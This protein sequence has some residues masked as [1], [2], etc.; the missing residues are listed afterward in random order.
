MRLPARLALSIAVSLLAAPM[1]LACD[2]PD[3]NTWAL[4]DSVPTVVQPGDF[5]LELDMASMKTFSSAATDIKVGEHTL[6]FTTMFAVFDVKRVVAGSYSDAKAAVIVPMHSCGSLG[7]GPYLLAGPA[8]MSI[9]GTPILDSRLISWGEYK[10]QLH[11]E[12]KSSN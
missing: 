3:N 7:S 12:Q 1:A 10:L 8:D 5:L 2:N 11:E 4:R 6:A 9:D